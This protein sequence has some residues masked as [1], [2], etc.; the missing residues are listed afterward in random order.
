MD[1]N[2][3][4]PAGTGEYV[5]P[6]SS[7]YD[8]MVEQI[9][10]KRKAM[11]RSVWT[12]EPLLKP[13]KSIW[14]NDDEEFEQNSP[15]SEPQQTA[16]TRTASS[17]RTEPEKQAEQ[18]KNDPFKT[19]TP[20]YYEPNPFIRDARNEKLAFGNTPDNYDKVIMPFV[21]EYSVER[22]LPDQRRHISRK[23]KANA[24]VDYVAQRR[25]PQRDM[26]SNVQK[27]PEPV[28]HQLRRERFF[29]D[30]GEPLH[31]HVS[32]VSDRK[33][34]KLVPLSKRSPITQRV[35]PAAKPKVSKKQELRRMEAM[36][37]DM[38]SERES[39]YGTRESSPNIAAAASIARE[40][41]RE[42]SGS[43]DITAVR[44]STMDFFN[45]AVCVGT[46]FLIAI[47][48]LVMTIM[49]KREKESESEKR[50]L[51]EFPK[52]SFSSLFKGDFTN[53]ITTY[54]TDTIPGRETFKSF[55]SA[56]ADCFG[57][58]V[59]DVKINGTIKKVEQEKYDDKGAETTKVTINTAPATTTQ[60]D[61]TSSK[62]EVTK[63]NQKKDEV[64]EIP[65]NT[66][67]GKMLG[68]I[69][70]Y[71][72]GKET[73]GL[74]VSF[75][76]FEMGKSFAETINKWKQ[77]LGDGVNVYAMPD[78]LSSAF[79]MPSNMKDMGTDQNENIKN[80]IGNLKGVVGVNC[81]NNLAKHMNEDI[82]ARTDHHWLPLGAYYATQAFAEAAQVDYPSL[83][84]YDKFTKEGF[85]GTFYTYS[86]YDQGIKNNP[87]TFTYFKPKNIKDVKCKYY[88]TSFS[89]P[90]EPYGTD[91]SG[92]FYDS[93]EGSNC[94]LSF[95]GS[96][97]EIVEINTPCKNN[98]VLVVY[99]NS[100]GNAMIPFL[101]N[102]FSKIYVCDYR[103]FDINGV[104]FCKKV[105]CTDLLFTG[106][107]SLIC[108]D[109]GINS[110]NNIRVQ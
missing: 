10:A 98:R 15:Q 53:G 66:N 107:I 63:S 48:L 4:D 18:S 71:G 109:V 89:N 2:W 26:H 20:D 28:V 50:K 23:P 84:Q 37:D 110:I 49:G 17:V 61:S 78:P 7:E 27:K 39:R 106:A 69:V 41:E 108:S 45:A 79:Y 59:G 97:A 82:Y 72:T 90:Y 80:I 64:V 92:L 33:R 35:K 55:N 11:S 87:D 105:G 96:D 52:F 13:Y 99:K 100:Y 81:V 12:D 31:R 43:E 16:E 25:Q 34:P 83:D 94:Y 76:T 22:K 91:E 65:E 58:S 88:D 47:V 86:N 46:I 75:V 103:Y 14:I 1:N 9:K 56:F 101:T 104:D 38:Q 68:D 95:L 70:V 21:N 19:Y 44:S 8:K 29:D 40:P 42:R 24:A 6:H 32:K 5:S 3:N 62:P 51:A 102:S 60:A 77:D 67:E 57:F 85:L 36:L 73:R 74:S 54:F 30:E 93:M